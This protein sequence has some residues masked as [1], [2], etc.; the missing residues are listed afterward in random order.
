LCAVLL[1]T[2]SANRSQEPPAQEVLDFFV[3]FADGLEIEIGNP[4]VC[5][6]DLNLTLEDLTQGFTLISQGIDDYSL[7]KVETGLK[8]WA[9]ALIEVTTA[10]TDCG[11]GKI[12]EDIEKIAQ[13]I[14]SG[15]TG[16]V[17]FIA[18]EVLAILENDVQKL[19][20]DAVAA[21]DKKDFK[22]AGVDSGKIVGILLN[23]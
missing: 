3:G 15:T 16:L 5:A 21:V 17:E 20:L 13:E 18:R 12:A 19:F 1:F 11:A 14:N 7:S 23:Q 9:A 2:V 8:L 4:A 10:L 22:T 6:K